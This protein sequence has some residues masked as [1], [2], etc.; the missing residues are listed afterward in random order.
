LTRAGREA[1]RYSNKRDAALLDEKQLW[2]P[3]TK[4]NHRNY[5]DDG[6]C[7]DDDGNSY[8]D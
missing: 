2:A 4:E 3:A 7:N 5:R 6:E 1:V 8:S